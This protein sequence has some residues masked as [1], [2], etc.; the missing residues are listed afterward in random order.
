MEA[1]SSV[2]G[3]SLVVLDGEI[4]TPPSS[5]VLALEDEVELSLASSVGVALELSEAS[6]VVGS[7]VGLALELSLGAG[8]GSPDSLVV[9]ESEGV[10]VAAGVV[11]ASVDVVGTGVVGSVVGVVGCVVGSVGAGVVGSVGAVVVGVVGVSVGVVG[12]TLGVRNTVSVP[13]GSS[14]TSAGSS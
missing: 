5:D 2:E 9:E 6:G 1:D 12:A 4:T 10:G 7:E 13:A 11:G 14:L 8:V 3:A